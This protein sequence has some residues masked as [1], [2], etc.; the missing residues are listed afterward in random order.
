MMCHN[1]FYPTLDIDA[2]V[3]VWKKLFT[4]TAS[5]HIFPVRLKLI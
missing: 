4:E 5:Q 3:C 1:L 2:S